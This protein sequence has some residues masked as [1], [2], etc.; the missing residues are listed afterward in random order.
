MQYE[1]QSNHCA[2]SSLSKSARRI[3]NNTTINRAGGTGGGTRI[4]E[5]EIFKDNNL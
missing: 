5:N 1:K 3:Y 2:F 4:I